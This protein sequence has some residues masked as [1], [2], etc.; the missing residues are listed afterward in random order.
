MGEA[1]AAARAGHHQMHFWFRRAAFWGELMCSSGAQV[2]T[3]LLFPSGVKKTR[4]AKES[5][6]HERCFTLGF[7]TDASFIKFIECT[8]FYLDF[9]VQNPLFIQPRIILSRGNDSI[10]QHW[11]LL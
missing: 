5:Q 10:Q 11:C 2:V 1:F 9:I 8:H 6:N 4:D 7:I 3:I